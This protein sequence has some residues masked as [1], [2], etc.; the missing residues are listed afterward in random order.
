MTL[1]SEAPVASG[2]E[3]TG[4]KTIPRTQSN[5]SLEP[6]R[7]DNPTPGTE[8]QMQTHDREPKEARGTEVKQGTL[9]AET[10]CLPDTEATL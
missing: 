7:T 9:E 2:D 8:E 4:H 3:R 5:P 10:E 1:H 6:K